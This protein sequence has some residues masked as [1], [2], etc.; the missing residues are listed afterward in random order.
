[1]ALKRLRYEL[2]RRLPDPNLGIKAGPIDEAN[3]YV[4]L[5][6]I[7]G[8]SGTPY[9]GGVFD[10]RIEFTTEY[11]FKPPKLKFE[12]MIF[13]PNISR[14]GTVC[15]DILK[16]AWSPAL[17]ITSVLVSLISLLDSP[18]PDDPM[19]AESANLFVT[20]RSAYERIAKRWTTIYASEGKKAD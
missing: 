15:I 2:M 10:V 17:T 13:H 8:P 1:M 18:N 19:D 20:D 3:L 4:W 11:P 5:A 12:T 9:E 6:Q 16:K 7:T 14:K